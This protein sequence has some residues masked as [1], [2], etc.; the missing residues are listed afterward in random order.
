[1]ATTLVVVSAVLGGLAGLGMF[2][3]LRPAIPILK[4]LA[5][6]LAALALLAVIGYPQILNMLTGFGGAIVAWLV[7]FVAGAA[8]VWNVMSLGK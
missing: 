3:F 4:M 6:V 5:N 7:A 8:I 2:N 1:M